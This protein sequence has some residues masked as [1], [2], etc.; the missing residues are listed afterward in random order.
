M[1]RTF[2]GATTA[3]AALALT[4]AL[5]L[6]H[7]QSSESTTIGGTQHLIVALLSI[8]LLAL[9]PVIHRLGKLGAPRVALV[10]IVAQVILG[11]LA[12]VSNVKGEDPSFF[13]AVAAPAN[14]AILG[15]WIA[16]A[17]ILRRRE[18][19]PTWPSPCRWPTSG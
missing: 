1:T 9:V 3:A 16:L 17:V 6:T 19:I 18:A 2:L 14:L 12:T 5:Q 8:T 4:A 13:A 10:P 15:G 7:E 11:A